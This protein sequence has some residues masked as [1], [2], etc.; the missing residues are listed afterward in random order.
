MTAARTLLSRPSRPVGAGAGL[1]MLRHA[2]R[3]VLPGGLVVVLVA[4][5]MTGLVAGQYRQL[6][7]DSSGASSLA[8]LAESPAIRVLFGTPVALDTTGGFTVWRTG[9]PVA[10]LVAVWAVLTTTRLTRGDEEAGRWDG[11]LAGPY[12]IPGALG[13]YLG[14]LV[15][16]AAL[17]GA[18][19]ATALALARAG[20]SGSLRYGAALFLTGAA[21][22]ALGALASQLVTD[23]RRA[24]TLAMAVVGAGL[25]TRML[26]DGVVQLSWL[27]WTSPY[28][29]LALTEPFA[30]NRTT[31]LVV[32]LGLVFAL[33]AAALLAAGRRD[34][35]AGLL[36][37]ADR[38]RPRLM[39]LGSTMQFAIRRAVGPVAAWGSGL[40]AYFLLI[41]GLAS[42]LTRFL[43]DNPRFAELAATA[44]FAELGTVDGYVAAMLTLL[45]IPVGL[46]AASRVST[47]VDDE[48]SGRSTMLFA[49]P[50]RRSTWFLLDT[51]VAGIGGLLVAVAAG[52]ACWVGTRLV[53]ADL[54]LTSALAGALN[55]TP[56]LLL[57]L[58]CAVLGRGWLPRAAFVLGA[59]PCA[60]G[61]LLLTLA[62]TLSWP[63]AVRTLSPYAH[64]NAVPAEPAD[65][66]GAAGLL[67]IGL[68]LGAF[69]LLGYHR[70]DLATT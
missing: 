32:L 5:G 67:L 29:L 44:G 2:A 3:L 70:R 56:V 46:F 1:A 59:L 61:F 26:G 38:R 17:A 41:G 49:T 31:P 52:L 60:G 58:G 11:L 42:S 30:A 37:A 50:T 19:T 48:R 6:F 8:V 62:D 40:L 13:Y 54:S 47:D 69:G 28:G 45:A 66:P 16:V 25:A 55:T 27:L 14:V 7:G 64:L 20:S 10:V 23:H 68:L 35:H 43:T 57:S 12:R 18:G 9:T 34:L 63:T 65:W 39:L 24:A 22:A 15:V 21:A 33:H 51:A 53:E 4:A 36:P